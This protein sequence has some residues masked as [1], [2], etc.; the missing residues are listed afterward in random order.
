MILFWL[1]IL[2]VLVKSA[3]VE[4]SVQLQ[5]LKQLITAFPDH[6]ISRISH[7]MYSEF[8]LSHI[9]YRDIKSFFIKE[10]DRIE[11]EHVRGIVTAN[12]TMNRLELFQEYQRV[13]G[14]RI[15]FDK[16]LQLARIVNKET[17]ALDPSRRKR[18]RKIRSH[19]PEQLAAMTEMI[20]ERRSIDTTVIH[21][22]L[23][24]KF[25]SEAVSE[26]SILWWRRG[27]HKTI[28]RKLDEVDSEYDQSID[29]LLEGMITGKL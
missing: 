19:P 25:G 5:Y 6:D 28:K 26:E 7:M 20:A 1:Q 21:E 3:G 4:H 2:A 12:P 27:N 22:R 15:T 29:T 17:R 14:S 23:V 18:P 8:G 10:R 24:E 16:F 11:T 9:P 13:R